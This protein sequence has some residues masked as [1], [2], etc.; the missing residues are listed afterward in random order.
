M[1]ER[2]TDDRLFLPFTE[3]GFALLVTALADRRFTT[4]PYFAFGTNS[5]VLAQLEQHAPIDIASFFNT[6]RPEFRS[7]ATNRQTGIIAGYEPEEA[8][9]EPADP[10][11]ALRSRRI[12]E[13]RLRPE[14]VETNDEDDEPAS[15]AD[16]VSIRSVPQRR[17]VEHEEAIEEVESDEADGEPEVLTPRQLRDRLLAAEAA[18]QAAAEPEPTAR[19]RDPLHWLL[20]ALSWIV[21][22]RN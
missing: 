1:I 5:D 18:A 20:D 2:R 7:R 11:M 15:D 4:A 16:A 12:D 9:E 8:I 19:S 13:T 10:S 22:K 3:Q 17:Q 14:A 6:D 21:G